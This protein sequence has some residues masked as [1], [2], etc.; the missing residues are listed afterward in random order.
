MAKVAPSRLTIYDS[1]ESQNLES[2]QC[3]TQ[4]QSK[5]S[6]GRSTMNLV[7]EVQEKYKKAVKMYSDFVTY[8]SST[9]GVIKLSVMG[10]GMLGGV[11]LAFRS[12]SKRMWYRRMLPVGTLTL[13]AAACHPTHAYSIS[14]NVAV[15]SYS[16]SVYLY[17]GTKKFSSYVVEK[18]KNF[19]PPPAEAPPQEEKVCALVVILHYFCS[20]QSKDLA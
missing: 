20:V 16:A 19:T 6:I 3:T 10:V 4:T 12:N 9:E 2:V 5:T 18:Y 14:K 11:V 1:S 8:A 17:N 7:S 13:A 15:T